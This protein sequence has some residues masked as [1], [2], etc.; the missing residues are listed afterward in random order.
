MAVLHNIKCFTTRQ[1]HGVTIATAGKLSVASATRFKC[2][3]FVL[4]GLVFPVSCLA[5]NMSV[6]HFLHGFRIF[7][8][9]PKGYSFL[10]SHKNIM[11]QEMKCKES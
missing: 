5:G 10:P 11:D 2:S 9:K 8:V 6:L 3:S 4:F 7:E 1:I